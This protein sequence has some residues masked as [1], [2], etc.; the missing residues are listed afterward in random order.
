MGLRI[1]F[2]RADGRGGM[3]SVPNILKR[4]YRYSSFGPDFVMRV[5]KDGKHEDKK[6]DVKSLVEAAWRFVTDKAAKYPSCNKYFKSLPRN[7]TLKE[8]LDEGD[9]T[10]HCLVPKENYT[11]ADV[12]FGNTAGRDIGIN[13]VL[14]LEA[15]EQ[16]ASTLIHELAHV[17]GASTNADPDDPK[18]GAAELALKYCLCSKQYDPDILGLAPPEKSK[19]TRVV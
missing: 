13:P 10:I 11:L 3:Y 19:E 7:K 15:P 1:N 6:I 17:A 16:L 5:S 12:P 2:Q 8:V 4:K 18:S 14:F 9:I